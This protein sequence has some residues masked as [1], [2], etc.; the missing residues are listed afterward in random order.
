MSL[1]STYVDGRWRAEGVPVEVR[2]PAD[3][4]EVVEE[5][6]LG[7]ASHVDEA[8][9]A[10]ERA[11]ASWRRTPAAER[12]AILSRAAG[13]LD[14]RRDAIAL[15][16]VREEGKIL[17]D[18]TAEVD[19]AAATLRFF[20]GEALQPAGDVLP[21]SKP[22]GLLLTRRL[23]LGPLA[24][25]TP[26]NFPILV[27]AW[28]IGPALAYGNTVV[29]KPSEL[30]PLTAVHLTAAFERAGLPAGVLNVVTGLGADVGRAVVEHAAT[31]A[32]T[33]TGSTRVGREIERRVAGRGV[34]LQ[35]E[36]G[37]KN[38]AIVLEDAPLEESAAALA[39]G[40]IA[41]A[42]QRCVA[43]S[44]VVA[45]RIIAD[46][47]VEALRA[48]FARWPLG[49]G[50]DPRIR[51][52]PLITAP[53]AARV[54]VGIEE[55]RAAGAVV[56][57]GGGRGEAEGLERGHFVEPTILTGVAPDA[58]IAQEEVFGPV[59]A[60]LAVDDDEEAVAVA[61]GTPYGLS[62]A[63]LTRDLERAL[64]LIDRLDV[65]MVH[66]NAVSCVQAHVPFGGFKDSGFGPREQGKSAADFFTEL[67][68]V[69]VQPRS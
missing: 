31:R 48:E 25:V 41:G 46:D 2:N 28:K 51:V 66:V 29:W 5:V 11:F 26:F 9:A 23:P 53:A 58:R 68:V 14:E 43:I 44:R 16:L 33:F 17:A 64:G 69:D 36:M 37:G 27:P 57:A 20:A 24:V 13:E 22:A 34:K 4:S 3:V 38:V 32:V 50:L 59:L 10:A 7:S 65:G 21:P 49:N 52:G 12:A 39:K 6:I 62:A 15:D 42:G 8:F 30:T 35:L 61:N 56:A 18:A 19:R 40:S 55:A 1:A 67:Q 63:V 45:P 60:L 47:L 54:I